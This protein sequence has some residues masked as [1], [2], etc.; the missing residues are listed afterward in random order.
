MG[1][2]G[3]RCP[4]ALSS[5]LAPC[6]PNRLRPGLTNDGSGFCVRALWHHCFAAA[7][8]NIGL[9]PRQSISHRPPMQAASAYVPD[10]Y[11]RL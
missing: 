4:G 5:R 6:F 3:W 7:Y 2:A 8:A 10:R 1:S 11:M 9:E